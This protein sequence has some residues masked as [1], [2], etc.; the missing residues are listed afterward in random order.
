MPS[1]ALPPTSGRVTSTYA[2]LPIN[3]TSIAPPMPTAGIAFGRPL[4]KVV[5]SPVCGSTREILPAAPSVT[6]SAPS[7]PTVLP[8][9]PCRPVTSKV[10]AG[11][12]DGGGALSA[13]GMIIATRAISSELAITNRPILFIMFPPLCQRIFRAESS[14]ADSGRLAAL[15]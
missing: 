13:D 6:Y 11:L 9:A 12:T 7:G 3:A 8:E 1:T 10:P 2:V 4:A 15:V 14:A 5:R